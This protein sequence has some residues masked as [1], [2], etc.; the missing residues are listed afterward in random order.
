VYFVVFTVP[1]TKSLPEHA[2]DAPPPAN[3]ELPIVQVSYPTAIESTPLAMFNCPTVKELLPCAK[4]TA[5][6]ATEAPPDAVT[7]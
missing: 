5:P 3:E 4:F 6:N 1:K 7:A 2:I